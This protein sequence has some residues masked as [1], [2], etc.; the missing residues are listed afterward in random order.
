MLIAIY[1]PVCG[2]GTAKVTSVPSLISPLDLSLDYLLQ[3]FFEEE[4]IPLLQQSD[5]QVT[6]LVATERSEHAGELISEAL[7][8]S[9]DE[10]TVILGSGDGT[11]HEIINFLSIKSELKGPKARTDKKLHFVLVPCGTANALYSSIFSPPTPESL[12]D[13]AYRLQSV[14]SFIS[15]Q[16][17][18]PLTLAIST[19]SGPPGKKVAPRGEQN[20]CLVFICTL[21]VH[22]FSS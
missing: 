1:N 8:A 17:I 4:V 15:G 16:R 5:K 19:L 10:I 9:D 14:R 21:T 12:N 2:N 7:E 20:S 22:W 3:A 6:K 13:V 11:L 18:I